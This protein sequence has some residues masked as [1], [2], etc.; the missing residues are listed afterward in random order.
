MNFFDIAVHDYLETLVE[1]IFEYYV[2]AI[3]LFWKT[4]RRSHFYIRFFLG[5]AVILGISF[6]LAIFY[7][8]YG[9]TV[10][11]RT[12][13][14]ILLFI[15]ALAHLYVCF[16]K[17]IAKVIL[18]G[19][20][21]YLVQNLCYKVFISVYSSIS[22]LSHGALMPS[23]AVFKIIY[24]AQFILQAALAYLF[25][26][27]NARKRMLENPMPK[28]VIAVSVFTVVVS[29]FLSSLQD[30][31]FQV[32]AEDIYSSPSESIFL[33]RLSGYLMAILLNASIIIMIFASSRSDTLRRNI[34]DLQQLVDQS[35]KQ[36]E[37]SQ[38]TI[39]SINIT[40]HDMKHR[41]NKIVGDTLPEDAIRDINDTI[42]IYDALIDTGNKTLDVV[43]TEK[44]LTCESNHIAFTKTVDGTA[45]DF[46]SVGD[47]FCLFGNLLDNAIEAAKNID[48]PE[49]RYIN[50]SLTK[51]G[52][53]IT[54]IEC[55]NY[56]QGKREFKEGLPQTTKEDTQNHGFGVRSIQEIV[57]RYNGSL[58]FQTEDSIFSVSIVFYAIR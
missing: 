42:A 22:F 2:F 53:G 14:Y 18:A 56:Y 45:V 57:R 3:A 50:L 31:H 46:M 48:D 27:A 55:A 13:T 12:F 52:E 49:K 43:L 34:S 17:D 36:Y 1:W 24:Y 37:I 33:L 16:D 5:L 58:S 20:F 11:G 30:V 8:A 32:I 26:I 7:H 35:A 10:M 9:Q 38:Q 23:I 4:E 44:S 54:F 29:S 28:L 19:D 47:I 51:A 40:C 39:D 25:L 15:M 41:I 21:A 6:P